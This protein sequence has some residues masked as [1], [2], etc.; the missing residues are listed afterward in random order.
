MVAL[1]YFTKEISKRLILCVLCS[2]INKAKS[3]PESYVHPV[4]IV[5]ACAPANIIKMRLI[6]VT[7]QDAILS[8]V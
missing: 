6:N 7:W 3:L 5:C 2:E 1:H 8:S 4:G